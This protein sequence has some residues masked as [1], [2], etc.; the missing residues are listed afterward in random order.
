MYLGPRIIGNFRPSP[1]ERMKRKPKRER[2]GMDE[3]YLAKL[4]QLPCCVCG[5]PAPNTVHHLRRT[6][7]S[8]F[9]LRSPDKFALPMCMEGFSGTNDCHGQVQRKSRHELEWF[10]RKG[11]DAL[12][13]CYALYGAKYSVEAMLRVLLAHRGTA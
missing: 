7:Q 3:A 6:G 13:L 9:G 2:D 11:I 5:N 8:G 12:A 1:A 10:Q 4:R